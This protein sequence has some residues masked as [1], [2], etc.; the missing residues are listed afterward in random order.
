MAYIPMRA[1]TLMLVEDD[2]S[3]SQTALEMCAVLGHKVITARDGVEALQLYRIHRELI[4]V[5]LLDLNMP[6]M[7]GEETFSELKKMNEK[8]KVVL[9][10]GYPEQM[11][12]EKFSGKGLA[13]YIQKPYSFAAICD[14]LELIVG[15]E[16]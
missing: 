6:R 7:D 14:K 2:E 5:V 1:C 15:V 11:I 9:V 3:V 4:D 12:A 8:V 10:S 13:G 16:K